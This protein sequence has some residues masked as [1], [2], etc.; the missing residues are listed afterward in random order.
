MSQRLN[1]HS[2]PLDFENLLKPIAP[3]TFFS[4]H[5]E[6]Q[7]LHVARRAP[8]FYEN[9]LM[10]ADVEFIISTA[11]QL[12]KTSV[13]LLGRP[14]TLSALQH[15]RDTVRLSG[16]FDA[17]RQ[18]ATIRVNGAFRYWQPLAALCREVER[19]FSFPVRA[20][21]YCTPAGAQGAA[22]HYDTHDVFVM[23]IGG[24]KYWRVFEPLVRLP[25]QSFP[26]LAFERA[27]DLKYRRGA[28]RQP[29]V[30]IDHAKCG[31]PLFEVTLEAGDLLYLPR[32][33]VHEARAENESS[34]H[35][36][37]GIHVLTW[38][39]A[40][41]VALG[42][43]GNQVEELRK[44]LPVGFARRSDNWNGTDAKL[45]ALA[46]DF[47]TRADGPAALEEAAVNFISDQ[48]WLAER[49]ISDSLIAIDL[50]PDAVVAHR[51]GLSLRCVV[52]GEAVLIISGQQTFS[53]PRLLLNTVRFIAN[54]RQF[55]LSEIPG[56]LSESGKKNLVKRLIQDGF[57][58]VAVG[59]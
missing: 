50:P 12:Q 8:S 7:P 48:Q 26:A 27:E 44:S 40:L 45:S 59:G 19:E 43:A 9:L 49:V 36:S 28:T 17:Y 34:I 15:V 1:A 23:Q 3:P 18:G 52:T 46:H 11:Y 29:R 32:G 31:E 4:E 33:F 41:T 10:P 14:E 20:N 58:R 42:Q 39:D 53:A 6:T 25:L 35:V 56:K 51:R 57:L 2:A 24:R 21:L 54:T 13:E 16:L 38:L 22:L 5:W 37:L 55:K 47:A 30:G